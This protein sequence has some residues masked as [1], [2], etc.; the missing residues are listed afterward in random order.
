MSKDVYKLFDVRDRVECMAASI[1]IYRLFAC[2]LKLAPIRDPRVYFPLGSS[3][4][5]ILN[6]ICRPD[7]L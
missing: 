5:D 6:R 7:I 1:A 3:F 2:L 4:G